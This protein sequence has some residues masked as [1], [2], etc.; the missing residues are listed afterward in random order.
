MK[1]EFLKFW[2]IVR[3]YWSSRER[4]LSVLLLGAVIALI[5]GAAYI[6]VLINSWY[7]LFYDALQNYNL[8][9]FS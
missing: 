1:S 8:S 7:A 9:D 2:I 6:M 3:P 4:V 5:L